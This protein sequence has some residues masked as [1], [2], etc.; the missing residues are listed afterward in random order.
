MS[1]PATAGAGGCAM[2]PSPLRSV[3]SEQGRSKPMP[4]RTP[5]DTRD[6]PRRA[7]RHRWA[8]RHGGGRTPRE[9][10]RGHD[11]KERPALIAGVRRP[12]GVGRHAP[13][14]LTVKTVQQAAD[15]AM[16]AGRKRST[17]AASRSRL[18]TG[19]A[20]DAVHHTQKEDARGA[21]HEQRAESLFSVLK[22]YGRV[23]RGLSKCN[24]PGDVGFLQFLRN[25][26]QL[27]AFEQ[28]EMIL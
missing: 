13:R 18:S 16:Q 21:G 6:R 20:P 15:L 11:D 7:G 28:A 25:F 23:L 9:P 4:S 27:T 5:P 14:D 10:G 3:G 26:Y 12:G 17:D 8:A 22:P 19:S 24:L 2:R 1:A